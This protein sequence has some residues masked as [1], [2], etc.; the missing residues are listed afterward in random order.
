MKKTRLRNRKRLNLL[1]YKGAS[2]R[3]M[4]L[5]LTSQIS[6]EGRTWYY[7]Y[8]QRQGNITLYTGE[9]F[10]ENLLG[11]YCFP[12]IKLSRVGCVDNSLPSFLNI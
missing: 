8:E 2:V 5:L 12:M 4:R 10:L 6:L 7:F 1:S 9:A 11:T 3:E